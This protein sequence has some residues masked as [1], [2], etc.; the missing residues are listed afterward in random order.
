MVSWKRGKSLITCCTNGIRMRGWP[1]V[2]QTTFFSKASIE[3][4]L[5]FQS[6][7]ATKHASIAPNENPIYMVHGSVIN[8]LVTTTCTKEKE[9]AMNYY[10]PVRIIRFFCSRSCSQKKMNGIR[11][12]CFLRP[13]AKSQLFKIV[14]HEH[15]TAQNTVTIIYI[16]CN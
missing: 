12:D 16:A 4:Q 5:S 13:T 2:M 15:R 7:A 9:M 6:T 3:M 10:T 8:I 14:M 1:Y 11:L